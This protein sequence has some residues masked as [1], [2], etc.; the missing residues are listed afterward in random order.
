M[1]HRISVNHYN[2]TARELL[3][4][5][6]NFLVQIA[7]E[8]VR[9]SPRRYTRKPTLNIPFWQR[10]YDWG[11]EQIENFL[12]SVLKAAESETDL[13]LGTLVFGVH[14]DYPDKILVID[15]QQRLRSIQNLLVRSRI[16]FENDEDATVF[17]LF[18]G[19][20]KAGKPVQSN[21][22]VEKSFSSDEQRAAFSEKHLQDMNFDKIPPAEWLARLRFRAVVTYF[23]SDGRCAEDPFDVF[24]SN[25][26]ANV[27]RQAK[28]LDDIDVTK[29]KLLFCLRKFG[30][31]KEAE[32][33]ACEWETARMLQLVP[34]DRADRGLL[35]TS[36]LDDDEEKILSAVPYEPETVQ[37]QFARYLL[38]VKAFAEGK[39]APSD[40]EYR[41]IVQERAFRDEFQE[42]NKGENREAIRAFARALKKVND[43]FLNNHN[44]LLLAR[45][46]RVAIDVV[47]DAKERSSL[48]PAEKRL[49]FFQ[50]YVSGGTTSPNWLAHRILMQLLR[51]L[52][53]KRKADASKLD[54]SELDVI[55]ERLETDLFS[56]LNSQ[57]GEHVALTARDWFLSRALFDIEG[58]P[59]YKVAVK[60][61]D[62][63]IETAAKSFTVDTGEALL[64]SLRENVRAF[65]PQELPTVTGAAE[66]EHWVALERGHQKD[67]KLE[68]LL[69]C[70]SNKAHIAEGLN[71]SMRNDGILKK[72]GNKDRSWWP[73]LQFLAAY[74]LCGKKWAVATNSLNLKNLKS[75]IDPLDRFWETV[76]QAYGAEKGE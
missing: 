18:H 38:L 35:N 39:A 50:G 68:E 47:E 20:G 40:K 67:A 14:S 52:A 36:V 32:E 19:L 24:M 31:E 21:E 64:R 45:R 58:N 27:N 60:G 15:G 22:E 28:P 3:A 6:E 72:A 34:T 44:F 57:A 37:V 66:R 16:F 69:D 10:D 25:L 75:F 11:K 51:E 49:L 65:R 12:S 55:L 9:K 5:P 74:S 33:F 43:L 71:Q 56:G 4:G 8:V 42:L 1:A 70:L 59:V 30:D 26:F 23:K 62:K 48:T 61:C 13:Y 17:P 76:G 46:N 29:A 73:T 63:M 7:K 53:K 2:L 54:D 41:Q